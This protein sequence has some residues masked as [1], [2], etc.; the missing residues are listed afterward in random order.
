MATD[1]G[2][3]ATALLDATKKLLAE[4]KPEGTAAEQAFMMAQD[5]SG[6]SRSNLKLEQSQ[7]VLLGKDAFPL[8][9]EAWVNG[10][11][12]TEEDLKGKVVLLDFWADLVRSLHCHVPAP[13]AMAGEVRRQRTRDHRRHQLLQ[14]WLECR[15]ANSRADGRNDARARAGDAGRV[16]QALRIKHRFAIMPEMSDF[17]EKYGVQGIPQVVVIDRQGKIRLVR[18]GAG[19]ETAEAI[20]SMLERLLGKAAHLRQVAHAEGSVV[21]SLRRGMPTLNVGIMAFEAIMAT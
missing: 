19:P 8:K 14:V 16:R 9:P 7:S 3:A 4:I 20:E 17:A 1:R 13:A 15:N 10:T 2:E 5:Q 18:V 6:A 21:K 12:L 11:P